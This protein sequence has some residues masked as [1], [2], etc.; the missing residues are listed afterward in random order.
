MLQQFEAKV[1][2]AHAMLTDN[3]FISY[4]DTPTEQ[5]AAD[6]GTAGAAGGDQKTAPA[7]AAAAAAG[8]APAVAERKLDATAAGA[9]KAVVA[10]GKSKTGAAGVKSRALPGAGPSKRGGRESTSTATSSQTRSRSR[11]GLYG[12]QASTYAIGTGHKRG[13]DSDDDTEEP[14]SFAA[15]WKERIVVNFAPELREVSLRSW[16]LL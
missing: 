15:V 8:A 9:S 2:K 16:S 1:Q 5:S 11:S 6:G 13:E 7:A 14:S 3:I 10:A 4:E 12:H